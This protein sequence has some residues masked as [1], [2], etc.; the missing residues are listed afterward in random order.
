MITHTYEYV[1]IENII[2]QLNP[3]FPSTLKVQEEQLRT[4]FMNE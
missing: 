3:H 4:L 2:T 1:T